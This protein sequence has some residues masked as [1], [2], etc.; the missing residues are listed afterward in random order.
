M[1]F[2]SFMGVYPGFC[3]EQF[4][5]KNNGVNYGIMFI[6]FSLAGIIGP[7][8]LQAFEAPYTQAYYIAI[9]LGVLGLIMSFVYRAMNKSK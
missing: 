5:P 9:G 2:G 1:A 6:G 8:V 4:G 7:K 3:A